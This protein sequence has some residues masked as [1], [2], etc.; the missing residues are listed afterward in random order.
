MKIGAAHSPLAIFQLYVEDVSLNGYAIPNIINSARISNR[1]GR[2]RE[3]RHTSLFII[4]I[5]R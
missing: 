5:S 3:S 4:Y 2:L 1:G